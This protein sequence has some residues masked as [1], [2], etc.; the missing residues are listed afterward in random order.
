MREKVVLDEDAICKEYAETG[1]GIEAMAL[2]YHVGKLRIKD[3]LTKHNIKFKRVGSQE[4]TQVFVVSDWKIKKYP[5]REGKIL[6]A[7]DRNTGFESSDVENR[8]G[9]L[10]TYIEKQ[11]GVKTPTLYDRR[12][13]YMRTGNYWWEQWFDVEYRDSKPV[14]KCPYCDWETVDI[15]NKSGMFITHLKKV[16]K[17]DKFEYIARHPEDKQYF[18]VVDPTIN[19]KMET[20]E[21]KFVTCAVCGEKF[22]RIDSKHLQKHKLSKFEYFQIYGFKKTLCDDS[23][24]KLVSIAE[25]VNQNAVFTRQS[26]AEIEIIEHIENSGLECKNNDRKILEGK[27]IDIFV[28]SKMIGIEYNGIMWHTEVGGN[29]SPHYHCDKLENCNKK[30]VK[31]ISIFEDEYACHKDVVMSKISHILR[32][33]DKDKKHIYGRNC[34]V[35]PC[36]S[37]EAEDFLK[38]N[39]LQ[40]FSKSTV[41]LGA[42][43]NDGLIGVMCFKSV[44]SDN[45]WELSRFATDIDSICCGVGG[46]LFSYFKKHYN[47]K[48]IKSFADRRWTVDKDDN[49]YTKLGFKLDGITKPD[50]RYYNPAIDRYMRFHK[51]A[52]R[53][54]SLLKKHPELNPNMTE[55]EMARSLGY[56]RIWDCGLYRY[57]YV[58]PE[59][60]E[61]EEDISAI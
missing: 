46:K 17:M 29:K 38:K 44:D 60:S 3:I 8:G 25:K 15:D 24:S 22:A 18:A 23:K 43:Y 41:Y 27:E 51:F 2:K 35:K 47:Y 28:P 21:R 12:M 16:H 39:H 45:E 4:S 49:L 52:F 10:T 42:Y 19:R 5:Q 33:E 34:I 11:Y 40:G 14:R 1:I 9:V 50:Y 32:I 57:V 55:W 31:L 6:Y 56:D 58:N 61:N 13:H 59:F 54:A 7:I 53:K 48:T 36:F 37:Y 26:K 20:D 30:G